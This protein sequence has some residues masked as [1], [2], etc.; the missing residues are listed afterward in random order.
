ME[1]I[2]ISLLKEKDELAAALRFIDEIA[3]RWHKCRPPPPPQVLFGAYRG[4]EIVGTIALDFGDQDR[5]LPI[6]RIW[7]FDADRTPLPFQ[8]EAI[9]QYGRWMAITPA[10]SSWLLYTATLYALSLGKK[11]FLAEAKT[12]I[13]ERICALGFAFRRIENA[14]ALTDRIPEE[15]RLYY[16]EDPPGLYMTRLE[17]MMTVAFSKTTSLQSLKFEFS[18]Q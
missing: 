1:N 13:M 6:E 11:Y 8:R 5:P 15:G 2:A 9:A 3:F 7:S 14:M 16:S 12:K 4:K 18:V 10:V 17:E